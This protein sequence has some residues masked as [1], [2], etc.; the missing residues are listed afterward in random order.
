MSSNEMDLHHRTFTPNS[1]FD[2][3]MVAIE[4]S[5][6]PFAMRPLSLSFPHPH[7]PISFEQL[8]RSRPAEPPS[9]RKPFPRL[10]EDMPLSATCDGTRGCSRA[11][12]HEKGQK[13]KEPSSR[14]MD[15]A[16]QTSTVK[17]APQSSLP[18]RTP[19]RGPSKAPERGDRNDPKRGP[20]NACP[21]KLSEQKCRAARRW[22]LPSTLF[23][24]VRANV[25]RAP[26]ALAPDRGPGKS[27]ARQASLRAKGTK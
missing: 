11:G 6:R 20:Q 15:S 1:V 7:A 8:I 17:H 9:L 5:Q 21:S 2:R 25:P 13:K 12:L 4:P 18:A 27:R 14:D 19:R 24:L 23:P 26:G 10:S 3:R 22:A 16:D